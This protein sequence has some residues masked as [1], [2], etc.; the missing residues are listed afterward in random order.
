[1]SEDNA[2]V[3]TAPPTSLDGDVLAAA[4]AVEERAV[5]VTTNPKHF[6][7]LATMGRTPGG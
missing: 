5:V 2:G 4:Q 7:A 1:M 6:T 3:V